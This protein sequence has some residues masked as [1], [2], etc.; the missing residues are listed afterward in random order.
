MEDWFKS[1]YGTSKMLINAWSRFI[2]KR[3]MA[4]INKNQRSIVMSPGYCRTDMGG[5]DGTYSV[6][7]GAKAIY[8]CIFMKH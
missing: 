2:M 3:K 1:S 5:A 7:S 6:E 4:E 8:D